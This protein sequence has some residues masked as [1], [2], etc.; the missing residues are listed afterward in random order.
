VSTPSGRP[1]FEFPIPAAFCLLGA[2]AAN[3]TTGAH[4]VLKR[5]PEWM[6]TLVLLFLLLAVLMSLFGLAKS[7]TFGL[8]GFGRIR[9][10]S[11]VLSEKGA[12]A[13]ILICYLL[14]W[15]TLGGLFILVIR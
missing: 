11:R 6:D 5:I 13:L 7:L 14:P 4:F 10:N 12:R 1:S 8:G 3:W 9:W 2:L 15:L